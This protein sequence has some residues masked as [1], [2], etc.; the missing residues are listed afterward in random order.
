MAAPTAPRKAY[1]VSPIL[2]PK[3]D[4]K[5]V[6]R[7]VYLPERLWSR[8]TEIGEDTKK[9]DPKKGYS[10]NEVILHFLE[11]ACREYELEKTEKKPR[12]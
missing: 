1:R 10:R 8:L 6:G 4:E 3:E 7:T 2:P 12:K 5:P 11:W 9:T